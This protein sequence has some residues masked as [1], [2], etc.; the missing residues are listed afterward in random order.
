MKLH[1]LKERTYV[2]SDGKSLAEKDAKHKILLGGAGA[3]IP[4]EQ[5]VA[6]GLA[7]A[8]ELAEKKDAS[9]KSEDKSGGADS[10]NKGAKKGPKAEKKDA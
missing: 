6:L 10:E 5:A 8:E 7:K 2:S 1:T 3:Q 9:K 4:G